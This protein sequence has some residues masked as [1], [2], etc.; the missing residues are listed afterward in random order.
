MRHLSAGAMNALGKSLLFWGCCWEKVIYIRVRSDK[1][2][3]ALCIYM[4]CG[5]ALS[6]I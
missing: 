6:I 5:W 3:A 4:L 1:I 2:P